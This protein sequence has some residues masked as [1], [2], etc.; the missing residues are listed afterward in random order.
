MVLVGV[1]VC[2]SALERFLGAAAGLC[3]CVY[4]IA[5]VFVI[6][7]LDKVL[8]RSFV[9]FYQVYVSHI[10]RRSEPQ[11]ACGP[12][13]DTPRPRRRRRRY[14][15]RHPTTRVW[16]GSTGL[17]ACLAIMDKLDL[18]GRTSEMARLFGIDFFSVLSRGSQYRVE[19]VM[20]R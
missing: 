6:T 16:R 17:Q 1:N 5:F 18:V 12:A 11:R 13:C 2:K 20:L 3:A 19:A 7:R 15:Y 8:R 10:V 9:F 14:R 4:L